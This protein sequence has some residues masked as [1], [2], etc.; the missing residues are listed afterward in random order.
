MTKENLMKESLGKT[1]DFINTSTLVGKNG[2]YLVFTSRTHS[3]VYEYF[4][5]N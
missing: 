1:I 4:T 5:A 2:L 3:I